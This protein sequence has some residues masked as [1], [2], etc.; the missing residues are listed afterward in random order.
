M[1]KKENIIL[2]TLTVVDARA[3]LDKAESNAKTQQHALDIVYDAWQVEVE[4]MKP[5]REA[6]SIAS[7]ALIK[8]HQNERKTQ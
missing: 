4:K 8:A 5:L 6:V 7:S 1:K 2:P 3:N